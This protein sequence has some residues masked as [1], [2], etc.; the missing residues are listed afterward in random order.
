MAFRRGEMLERGGGKW[1]KESGKCIIKS[2]IEFPDLIL[3]TLDTPHGHITKFLK[4][5]PKNAGKMRG[6]IIFPHFGV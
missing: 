1:N 2:R 4:K 3:I 5:C 6:K